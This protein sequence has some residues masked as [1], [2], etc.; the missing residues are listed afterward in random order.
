VVDEPA[1]KWIAGGVVVG[2]ALA[3]YLSTQRQCMQLGPFTRPAEAYA[4]SEPVST[5]DPYPKPGAVAFRGW[6]LAEY[7]G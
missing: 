7:S 5:C 6:I 1:L 2:G 3:W 4:P